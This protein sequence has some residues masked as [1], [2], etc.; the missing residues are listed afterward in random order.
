MPSSACSGGPPALRSFPTRR[1]SDLAALRAEL[2]AE[3]PPLVEAREP[4]GEV[5]GA[6]GQHRVVAQRAAQVGD[7]LAQVDA[8]ARRLRMPDP[9]LRSEEHTSEL[10]SPCNLVCRL[11][12]APAAPPL[13]ALSLHDALPISPLCGPSWVPKRRHW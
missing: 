9:R 10:Q 3:A 1:S 8:L 13:S 12:R 7:D 6:V 4:A 5:A 11:L 2:G